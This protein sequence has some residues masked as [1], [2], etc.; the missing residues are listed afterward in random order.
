MNYNS[1]NDLDFTAE[2]E[3]KSKSSHVTY[4]KH[5]GAKKQRWILNALEVKRDF[6]IKNTVLFSSKFETEY[7][8]ISN[9][10]KQKK[11]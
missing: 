11:I 8:A 3:K 7:Y 2:K 10:I 4:C 9:L 6:N 5:N 1:P